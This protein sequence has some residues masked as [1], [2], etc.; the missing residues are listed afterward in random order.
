MLCMARPAPECRTSRYIHPCKLFGLYINVSNSGFY[1]DAID[2]VPECVRILF[3]SLLPFNYSVTNTTCVMFTVYP[4]LSDDS[5]N[6]ARGCDRHVFKA[7]GYHA[8]GNAHIAFVERQFINNLQMTTI[9]ATQRMLKYSHCR[10]LS[11]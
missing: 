6:V 2:E 7:M 3:S 9:W 1:R 4:P 8:D 10:A 11:I 5:I